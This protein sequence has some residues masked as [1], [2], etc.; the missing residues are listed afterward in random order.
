[1]T[2]PLIQ[3]FT[4]EGYK[5]IKEPTEISLNNLTI[6]SGSNSSGKSSI[7]QPLLILKQTLDATFDPGAL[8]LNGPN[9]R[10]NNF[11]NITTKHK[12]KRDNK[13]EFCISIEQNDSTSI[14]I[15][16]SKSETRGIYI[17]TQTETTDKGKKRRYHGRHES[18]KI[19]GILKEEW[20]G[21]LPKFDQP[22]LSGPVLMRETGRL[23]RP[24]VTT[25][26]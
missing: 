9:A 22:Y 25:G 19:I 16:Y 12:N 26:A 17:K 20:G 6:F 4:V 21:A 15:T 5:S 1:M 23:D 8:L 13:R 10:I 24:V 14:A 7:F 11:E 18:S 2:A 3:S